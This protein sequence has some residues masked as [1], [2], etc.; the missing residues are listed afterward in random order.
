MGMRSIRLLL[1]VSLVGGAV[2]ARATGARVEVVGQSFLLPDAETD[3]RSISAFIHDFEAPRLFG[4]LQVGRFIASSN[5]DTPAGSL[6]LDVYS[7]TVS[8][9]AEY[10]RPGDSLPFAV[11]YTPQYAGGRQKFKTNGALS[12]YNSIQSRKLRAFKGVLGFF[13]RAAVSLSTEEIYAR[14][15]SM[16]AGNSTNEGSALAAGAS[17]ALG[18]KAGRRLFLALNSTFLDIDT[19]ESGVEVQSDK[20]WDHTLSALA[21]LPASSGALWRLLARA[22]VA[23]LEARFP[24]A[25]TRED[26]ETLFYA[27]GAG[28]TKGAEGD[29]MHSGVSLSETRTTFREEDATGLL[30]KVETTG[31]QLAWRLGLEKPWVGRW[32]GRV[33]VDLLTVA[34]FHNRD[35][36]D[37]HR[38]ERWELLPNQF[39]GVGFRASDTLS[40]DAVVSR[41]GGTVMNEADFFGTTFIGRRSRSYEVSVSMDKRFQ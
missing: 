9:S 32:T 23:E 15:A 6:T 1:A 22:G 30:D 38:A 24:G 7:N 8:G 13:G 28:W 34:V 10:V 37:R 5:Q 4:S 21:E 39:L 14:S 19:T 20:K 40:F 11:R 2:P 3:L 31:P 16:A 36:A 26:T 29:L 25:T 12:D 18:E 41:V 27:L 17:I 33:G 35:T